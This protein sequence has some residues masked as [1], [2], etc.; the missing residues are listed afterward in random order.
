MQAQPALSFLQPYAFLAASGITLV[1]NRKRPVSY[2]GRIYI[3]ASR[4]HILPDF[5]LAWIFKRMTYEQCTRYTRDAMP[6][7][8]LPVHAIIG[9]ATLTRI[10]RKTT[11]NPTSS[12]GT[13]GVYSCAD[14]KGEL[15]DLHKTA[16]EW[17]SPW[18]SGPFG[19]VLTDAKL[20][21]KPIPM[22]GALG[23]WYPDFETERPK[24]KRGI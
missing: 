8:V 19:L 14:L 18:F 13:G 17:F 20:Y 3:H 12:I 9:E 21:D 5:D 4:Y 6:E 23:L 11:P 24:R 16:P 1:D 10:M 7:G 22:M 2:R 15:E